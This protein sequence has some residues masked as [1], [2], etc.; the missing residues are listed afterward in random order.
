MASFYYKTYVH[1]LISEENSIV[2]PNL[3]EIYLFLIVSFQ[4]TTRRHV[5]RMQS[6]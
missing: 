4:P 2:C 3:N 1:I 5:F 6:P